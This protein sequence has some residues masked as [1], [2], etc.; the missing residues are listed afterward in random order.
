[1]LNGELVY[2]DLDLCRWFHKCFSDLLKN[3]KEECVNGNIVW[4]PLCTDVQRRTSFVDIFAG[5]RFFSCEKIDTN[6]LKET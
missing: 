2:G 6:L 3:P 1:M 4:V 5:D